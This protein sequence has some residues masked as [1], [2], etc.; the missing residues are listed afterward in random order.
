MDATRSRETY[1]EFDAHVGTAA[2]GCPF[3]VKLENPR[4]GQTLRS[5]ALD[6][7]FEVGVSTAPITTVEER[8][9][10]SASGARELALHSIPGGNS[11]RGPSMKASL[12]NDT[13]G[14]NLNPLGVLCET[15]SLGIRSLPVRSG[16]LCIRCAPS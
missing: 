7:V 16:G 8:R 2:L 10:T 1:R 3:R 5:V 11:A 6:S 9:L 4:V 15:I 14:S 13:R 12:T